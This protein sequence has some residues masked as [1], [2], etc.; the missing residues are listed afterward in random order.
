[1]SCQR[2]INSARGMGDASS[3]KKYMRCKMCIIGFIHRPAQ[4]IQNVYNRFYSLEGT[5]LFVFCVFV[6]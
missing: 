1:M 6:L 4:I 3:E 5:V 2:K